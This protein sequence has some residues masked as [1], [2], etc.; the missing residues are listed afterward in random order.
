MEIE[1]RLGAAPSRLQ[2]ERLGKTGERFDVRGLEAR[3]AESAS[4]HLRSG[5]DATENPL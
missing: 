4:E 3:A 5:S 2:L 1:F